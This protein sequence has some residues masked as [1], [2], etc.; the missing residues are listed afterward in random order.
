M[1]N[2]NGFFKKT[3]QE[4]VDYILDEINKHKKI[5]A[6]YEAKLTAVAL[7]DIDSENLEQ[8]RQARMILEN[9]IQNP[10][11]K[12]IYKEEEI[13]HKLESKLQPIIKE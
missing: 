11:Q 12:E 6:N 10:I 2:N 3:Q 8:Q 7:D 5:I 1:E 13:I 4:E 9:P